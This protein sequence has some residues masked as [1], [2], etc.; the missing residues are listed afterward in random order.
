MRPSGGGGKGSCFGVLL[1]PIPGC[2]NGSVLILF[3]SLSDVVC[4]WVVWVR[5]T[6]QGLDGE[7]NGSDLEG[8]R[9]VALKGVSL[10][11]WEESPCLT[12]QHVQADSS[13]SVDVGV[14][15]LCEE[16]DLGWSHWVVVGQEEFQLEDAA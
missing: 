10:C 1:G 14:V 5:G 8:G 4:Q 7:Q 16:A 13:E 9:P 12:L 15:D 2:L 3:P 11:L 6:K